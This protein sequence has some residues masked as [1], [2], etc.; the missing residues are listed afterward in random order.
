VSDQDGGPP[1]AEELR[2]KEQLLVWLQRQ[3]PPPRRC[4]VCS[5]SK[6]QLDDHAELPTPPP[7]R[8]PAY[9]LFPVTCETCGY[10]FFINGH[11]A[12]LVDP[13]SPAGL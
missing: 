3:W 7:G 4:P 1:G 11:I 6:W 9:P 10:V 8:P 13:D 12:G 2:R 5:G